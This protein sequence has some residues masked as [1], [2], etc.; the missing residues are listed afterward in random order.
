[1]GSKIRTLHK[2][3]E[4]CGTQGSE[5]REILRCAQNDKTTRRGA[6]LSHAAVGLM[7]LL[8]APR[9]SYLVSEFIYTIFGGPS[10][11]SAVHLG[12]GRASAPEVQGLKP[13]IFASVSSGLKSR[14]PECGCPLLRVEGAGFRFTEPG[15]QSR[16][17]GESIIFAAISERFFGTKI[18]PSE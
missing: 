18:A 17:C 14:P 11:S 16:E 2:K 3:R 7:R 5:H 13:L 12:L 9:G 15:A 10:F 8:H 1:M 4:E 6:R